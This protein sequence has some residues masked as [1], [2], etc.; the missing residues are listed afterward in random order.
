[1]VNNKP[2]SWQNCDPDVRQFV[3]DVISVLKDQLDNN[4][5]GIYLHG[6]LAMGSYYRPKSDVDI[7]V[8]SKS[9]IGEKLANAAG[10][11]LAELAERRP[12]TGN[13]ELSVITAQTA[14][15]VPIPTPFE[16][17]YSS[18]WHDKAL[19]GELGYGNKTDIDLQSH[20]VYVKQRGISLFGQ[21][22]VDVF[23][24]Y[25]WQHFMDAVIDDFNWIIEGEHILETPFYGVLNICRTLQLLS[26]NAQRAHSKDEGGEW[27]LQNLPTQYNELIRKALAVYRSADTVDESKRRTGGKKWDANQLLAFRDFARGYNIKTI[28]I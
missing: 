8:V 11:A 16:L 1:M 13:L 2:Q 14:K 10:K 15:Q 12:T 6:S 4:L 26:E 7:I 23:G 24:E 17:H 3:D 20:L 25:D 21:P 18:D 28:D 5:I 22:I 19:G 27:G 9:A